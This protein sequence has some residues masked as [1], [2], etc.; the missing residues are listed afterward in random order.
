MSFWMRRM[1]LELFSLKRIKKKKERISLSEWE[2]KGIRNS[3]MSS[4]SLFWILDCIELKEEK[5][6]SQFYKSKYD[7]DFCYIKHLMNSH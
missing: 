6:N 2:T 4:F 7:M 1:I 3:F 5:K